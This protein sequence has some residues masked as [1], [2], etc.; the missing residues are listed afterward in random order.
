MFRSHLLLL[1]AV[2]LTA[3]FVIPVAAVDGYNI[4]DN[5]LISAWA[6]SG[7]EM[8]IDF[9]TT[10]FEFI[11]SDEY[12]AGGLI[13]LIIYGAI[14]LSICITTGGIGPGIIATLG[15]IGFAS[16]FFPEEAKLLWI[17]ILAGGVCGMIL[18][19]FIRRV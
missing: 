18:Y 8:G 6:F 4:H 5:D 16:I 9:V 13:I 14:I 15:T 17:F 3:M 7:D 1:V 12:G 10:L 19:P 11:V 2:L